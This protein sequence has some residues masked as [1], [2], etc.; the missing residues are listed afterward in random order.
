MGNFVRV[1]GLGQLKNPY[2]LFV[3]SNDNIMVC[4]YSNN[5]ILVFNARGELMASIGKGQLSSPR[6]VY[7]DRL[8]RILVTEIG[9]L[10]RE[11]R[12]FDCFLS[13]FLLQNLIGI[14]KIKRP[15]H[16]IFIAF[17]NNK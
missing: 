5:E 4:G 17:P 8:G 6:G 15:S 2:H 10:Q 14:S 11:C 7:M 13:S 9:K 12:S 16:E 3:D 1:V